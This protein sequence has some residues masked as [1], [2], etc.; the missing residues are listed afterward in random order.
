MYESIIA[1]SL[2][3]MFHY[4]FRLLNSTELT[5]NLALLIAITS[6]AMFLQP[7]I[8]LVEAIMFGLLVF[9]GKIK[10]AFLSLASILSIVF[11]SVR[12][13]IIYGVATLSTNFGTAI[14]VGNENLN[15]PFTEN[16]DPGA[17]N[18]DQQ[19]IFTA[20]KY[21]LLHPLELFTRTSKQFLEFFGPLN[22]AGLPSGRGSTW[23]HGLDSKRLFLLVSGESHLHNLYIF[24]VV[25]LFICF[26]L[27][28]F[29][30][31]YLREKREKLLLSMILGPIVAFICV[32]AISDG[33]ARYRIPV[34]PF[35][36][37]LFVIGVVSIFS[38]IF[39]DSK[40]D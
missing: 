37:S 2:M 39:P 9:N 38:R 13:Y 24:E 20:Y 4:F 36:F 21:L 33:D 3:L 28:I 40:S 15:I 30:V 12:N 8:V 35:C 22:G 1:S 31:L 5:I 7:K 23:H 18:Y 29:G 6:F 16:L 25:G 27:G 17:Q 11:L 34:M 26:L 19:Y 10:I 14:R 32:H